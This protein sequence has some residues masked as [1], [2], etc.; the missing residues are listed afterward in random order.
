MSSPE[1]DWIQ[2]PGG[3]GWMGG[4][5]R[6]EENPRHRV[7]IASF[8]LAQTQVT[9]AAYQSFLSAT[10][11]EPPDSWTDPAFAHP[12][13]PAVAVS[14]F[15]AVAYCAW[16]SELHGD[17]VRLPTEAE[18]EW[19]AR[20]ERNVLYPWG[21]EDPQT[22]PDYEARWTEGPEPVDAYPSRHPLG[23]LGLGEN[24]HE[25][26]SDW[27]D[28]AYYEVSPIVDPCGPEEGRRRSSRGGAWRHAVKVSRC[29]AR[30]SIPPHMR[31]TDYGFRLA[32]AAG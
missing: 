27:Y 8:R 28:R 11:H 9:R 21:D 7:R 5:P 3:S 1:S 6:L 24:V 2:V 15:D 20:A 18:W 22:L 26:C 25:W 29:S 10:D 14:W 23:F 32:A 13:M 4:G 19:A 31:Y 16:I 17:T 12:Q 30:S